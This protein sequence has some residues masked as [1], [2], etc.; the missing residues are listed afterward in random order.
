MTLIK[1]NSKF[2]QLIKNRILM[3]L[4]TVVKKCTIC[5][6][7]VSERGHKDGP[8][9]IS[10]STDSRHPADFADRS[11]CQFLNVRQC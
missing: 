1:L 10:G 7:L 11:L 6:H 2:K 3:I 8:G 9:Q 4:Y 5:V